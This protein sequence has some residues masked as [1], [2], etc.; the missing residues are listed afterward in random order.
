MDSET[1]T[2]HISKLGKHYFE[3][4]CTIVLR[5]IFNLRAINV[6][7][8]DD[9]GTDYASL[10]TY[11]ERTPV[12]YQ[13]TTQKTDIKNKAYR[14]AK[15]AIAKLNVKR[16][17][18]LTTYLLSETEIRILENQI[19][20]ELEIQSICLDAGSIAS[21]LLSE[22][23][24]GKF[25]D[26]TNYPLPNN[27]IRPVF[28]Y[29]EMALHSYTL[30]S[31]DSKKLKEN[32]YDDT[33]LFM[34]SNKSPLTEN[35]IIDQ[36]QDLL[37]LPAGKIEILK[38]RINGLFEKQ[39][40]KKTQDGKIQLNEKSRRDVESRKEIY[41]R[42]LVNLISAQT[43]LLRD[44]N[45]DWDVDD[46]KNISVWIAEAFICRQISNLKEIKASIVSHPIFENLNDDGI[47]KIRNYLKNKK[48]VKKEGLDEI[49]DELLKLASNHPLITKLSRASMYLALQG[50]NPISSAKAL[51]AN[52]WSDFKILVEPTIAIPYLC[53]RL[54]Y[55]S[56]NR[57]FDN[58]VRA[59]DRAKKLDSKLYI[60]YFYINECAGHLLQA[61]K[62]IGLVLDEN[63]LKFSSNAFVSNYYAL[64][65]SNIRVPESFMEYLSSYSSAIKTEKGD[66]KSWVRELMT[67]VQSILIRSNIEFLK[68][69]F[70]DHESC[71]YFEQEYVYYL[72]DANIDKPY[73]L[74]SHDIWALQFAN[75]SILQN[76]EHWI[77]MTYDNSLISF[78]KLDAYKGWVAN[79]FRF[80][81]LSS[82]TKPLPEMQ[83][84]S[85]L[86]TVATYSEQTL[87]VGARIM[88]RMIMYASKEMQNWEFKRDIETFKNELVQS[89]D[90]LSD[91]NAEI[92][93]K[94][95]AFLKERG[96]KLDINEEEIVDE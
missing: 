60:P 12:A 52:R 96:I 2:N 38:K 87:S 53:S 58:A 14:D 10:G 26:E 61:R 5:D 75:D 21:L 28:D 80:L 88:D 47:D 22:D 39:K 56:V 9:G 68:I 77:I 20:E 34:L 57:Y 51:G 15:K 41:Q 40:T 78:G 19:T 92:D 55:G 17:Y 37:A 90:Y 3:A 23:L 64:K 65:A 54:Y 91:Y 67:D 70:Y 6:D 33:I 79:P 83:F 95:D 66:I 72:R 84:I 4:A 7:G 63:E 46:L 30:L 8:R 76:D 44:H 50:S 86:H 43:D 18:F 69:P 82:A 81:D 32:I 24:L 73:H 71:K 62:Y 59:I 94:T 35:E 1:L 45:V 11:G 13:I 25:L 89:V 31:N 48:S 93:R 36:V 29:R 49:V 16:Y 27:Q 42:E 74:I 85:L